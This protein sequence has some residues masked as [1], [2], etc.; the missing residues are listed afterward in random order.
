MRLFKLAINLRDKD[1]FCSDM[2]SSSWRSVYSTRYINQ[3]RD[4]SSPT[5]GKIVSAANYYAL[6]EIY[7][8]H[9]Y[10]EILT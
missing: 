3:S 7:P 2:T 10:Y 6:F 8:A 9:A 5:N 4:M 1:I